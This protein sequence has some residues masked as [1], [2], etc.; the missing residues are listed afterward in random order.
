MSSPEGV[1]CMSQK[2]MHRTDRRQ[3]ILIPEGSKMKANPAP[4]VLA[5]ADAWA[6]IDGKHQRFKR[7]AAD[8]EFNEMDGAYSGYIADAESLVEDRKSVV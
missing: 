7:A 2:K 6:S 5:L 1:W 4:H 3:A 8:P